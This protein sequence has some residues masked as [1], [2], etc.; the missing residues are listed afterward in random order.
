MSSFTE[1]TQKLEQSPASKQWHEVGIREHHGF[2][3]PLFS[4][5][6]A[7]S[8]GI[9][10]YP[11]LHL[12]IDWTKSIG[13]DVIQLLPLNDTGQDSSPYNSISA[14][15]LNPIYL[16]LANLPNL[17]KHIHLQEWLKALQKITPSTIDYAK[18]REGKELF[19]KEYYHLER[20]TVL[21]QEDFKQFVLQ[22]PW[23]KG[24]ALF[25]VLKQHNQWKYWEEWPEPLQN[26][27]E[28]NIEELLKEYSDEIYYHFFI[29]YFCFQQMESVKNAADSRHVLIMGDIP[30]L[31][32]RD[33]A[34]VWLHR[35][36]F[37]M[38]YSAGAP[39]DMLGPD[40][41]DWG[42]PIYNWTEM[43]KHNDS[44]W[45]SRVKVASRLYNLYRIDHIV[46]FFRIWSISKGQQPTEGK[47]IPENVDD[48]IPQGKKIM[49]IKLDAS[50]MLP[51]GEDLGTIPPSVRVCLRELGICGTKV[52]RWE[53]MYEE[54]RRFIKSEDYPPESMTTVSTHD[55]Q[56]LDLWW[57]R[58][59]EEAKEFAAFK[60][61]QHEDK[62]SWQHH[63]DIL[64]DSHHTAS[65]FHINLLQEYLALVPNMIWGDPEDERINVPGLIS[66]RNWCYRYR[67]SLEEL[68]SNHQLREIMTNL[69]K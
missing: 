55:S 45:R 43:S 66:D 8:C 47:F 22:N 35:N 2:N 1:V 33:S 12:L 26:H 68:T 46:G 10:E 51:I 64:W 40:G 4:I 32:S 28:E 36:L 67:P 44:W 30:I 59:P 62:L 69:V 42:F 50:P 58:N 3:I 37:H 13:M 38:E 41:Q 11:D 34:D 63:Y 60:D 52:M 15:A 16:G 48:W 23:L 19:L 18:V 53:R 6:S 57:E 21:N 24:Y 39:P 61:W 65:L 31:I 17:D 56:P 49:L 25:K 29:Q 27:T 20:D 54:D 14:F 7:Q 9:G 5:H